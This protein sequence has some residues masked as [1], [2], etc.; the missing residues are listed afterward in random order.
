LVEGKKEK[1]REGGSDRLFSG[2]RRQ[3]LIAELAI[4][5]KCADEFA[6]TE[7]ICSEPEKEPL[8]LW[9]KRLL[10]EGRTFRE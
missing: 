8:E 7:D 9:E 3:L 2:V 5:T 4:L 6:Y 10:E 1:S